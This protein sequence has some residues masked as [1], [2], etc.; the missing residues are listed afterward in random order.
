[1]TTHDGEHRE[2]DEGG[3]SA[4]MKLR[5]ESIAAKYASAIDA[6]YARA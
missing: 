1:L 6:M 2:C 3:L 4:T 5:R